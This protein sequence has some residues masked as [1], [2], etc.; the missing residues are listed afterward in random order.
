MASSRGTQGPKMRPHFGALKMARTDG[1]TCYMGISLY[2]GMC[3]CTSLYDTPKMGPFW[4]LQL[5][6]HIH[7]SR[8]RFELITG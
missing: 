2:L 8:Y 4:G 3:K 6:H 5:A 1:D 7:G